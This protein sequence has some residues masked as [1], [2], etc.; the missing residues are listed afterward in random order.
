[1]EELLHPVGHRIDHDAACGCRRLGDTNRAVIIAPVETTQ[2]VSTGL[3]RWQIPAVDEGGSGSC[4]SPVN[5]PLLNALGVA[6]IGPIT[7]AVFGRL[8]Q[9]G[10][11]FSVRGN[12]RSGVG[13]V[14]GYPAA[15]LIECGQRMGNGACGCFGI[16]HPRTRSAGTKTR[17]VDHAEQDSVDVAAVI[18][19]LQIVGDPHGLVLGRGV[20]RSRGGGRLPQT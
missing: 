10:E 7:Y 19:V 6:R 2:L 1:M 16:I 12:R 8:D 20:R 5:G 15:A 3:G 4:C 13:V 11:H 18:Y 17:Q 14:C 9:V